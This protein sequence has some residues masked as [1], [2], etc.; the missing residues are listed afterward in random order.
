MIVSDLVSRAPK[1]AIALRAEHRTPLT[2]G[3]LADLIRTTTASIRASGLD[4][5]APIALMLSNG[6]ELAAAF[7]SLSAA[8]PVA[9]INPAF[10]EH[11]L[12][13]YLADLGAKAIVTTPDHGTIIHVARRLG[14]TVVLV[15]RSENDAAG[16]FSLSGATSR[17]PTDGRVTG[18]GDTA[19]L[20]HTSGT[21]AKPKLVA[22]THANLCASAHA[23]ASSLGLTSEDCALNIM[24]LFHVH[25]LVAAILGSL[26]AGGSVYCSPGFNALRFYGWLDDSRA[27]WYTAVPT[28]HQAILGRAKVNQRSVASHRLRFVRSCSAPLP[29]PAW[30]D[31]EGTFGVP[32]ISAYG[33]TEASHQISCTP[34]SYPESK[35][36]TVGRATGVELAIMGNDGRLLPPGVAGEVVIRGESVITSYANN[37][38]ATASSFHDG[39]F[40][41]GDEGH[42]GP[43]GY[44][45]LTGRLKEILNVGGEKV[46]PLE[47]DAALMEHPAVA[48]AVTFGV[49]D[50]SLG[51]RIAAVVVLRPER[52]ATPES[53]RSFVG[54]RLA[55]FKV[56]QP[57]VVRETIPTG[58]TGKYQRTTMARQL[59][60]A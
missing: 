50:P 18:S 30:R 45:R 16:W 9:P 48:Q 19:L 22:L 32:V 51:E 28:M 33:M 2:Y 38:A 43:D 58:P 25:G 29:I 57:I 44:L 3:R 24:P 8:A 6:P 36:G 15:E 10:K 47:V 35:R 60:L 12:E 56:P 46:S 14:L 41:T 31:I 37:P 40:K 59:G 11:E 7:V 55:K 4:E 1:S 23:V 13:F 39:W 26:A 20:L 53:L 17:H 54:E 49:P 34:A 42:L 52:P 27:S 21:T 5:G